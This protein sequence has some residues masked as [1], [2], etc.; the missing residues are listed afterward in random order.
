VRQ[1]AGQRNGDSD[2]HDTQSGGSLQDRIAAL[3]G[4][5]KRHDTGGST[6]SSNAADRGSVSNLT[7]VKV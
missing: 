7:S 2:A 5:G 3:Q 6:G 1:S 4:A